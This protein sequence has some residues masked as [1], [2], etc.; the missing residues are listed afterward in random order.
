MAAERVG[1][2]EAEEPGVDVPRVRRKVEETTSS[3]MSA[4]PGLEHVCSQ[5]TSSSSGVVRLVTFVRRGGNPQLD[6]R[7]VDK[8][9]KY[10]GERGDWR[11]WK[12][13]AVGW[14]MAVHPDFGRF[15]AEAEKHQGDMN[16]PLSLLEMSSFLHTELLAWLIGTQLALV[17]RSLPLGGTETNGFAAWR[18]LCQEEERMDPAAQMAVLQE[19]LHPNFEDAEGGWRQ[20]WVE[21]EA[22]L[23]RHAPLLGSLGDAV[24]IGIV[25]ARAPDL[26]RNHLEVSAAPYGADYTAFRIVVDSYLRAHGGSPMQ[27]TFQ[28]M[29]LELDVITK[30]KG[31]GGKGGAAR[32]ECFHFRDTGSCKWGDRCKWEHARTSASSS[33]R[34][35]GH[36]YVCGDR[37]HRAGDCSRRW[38]EPNE[39][40]LL[41]QGVCDHDD[42]DGA[43]P[44]GPWLLSLETKDDMKSDEKC[45][46]SEPNES[47]T[48][49]SEFKINRMS[50][51]LTAEESG[52]RLEMSERLTVDEL[53]H[54]KV[55][56]IADE[57][58]QGDHDEGHSTA[59]ESSALDGR[60]TCEEICDEM[61]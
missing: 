12:A 55:G 48:K 7:L 10:S 28:D 31:K 58:S 11:L 8:P 56:L 26:L 40:G 46:D 18:M 38:R 32:G 41:E 57:S 14:L 23:A 39:V 22:K 17:L 16:I 45:E 5:T 30:G 25:R 35:A 13:R 6:A 50:E 9:G 27:K 15:L 36:C 53:S 20:G 52:Q 2:A 3:S 19:L 47:Q 43:V 33:R 24:R 61:W 37:Q 42:D 54:V 49:V 29:P 34:S 1:D 60:S 4:P 51:C 59:D 44:P 21:W